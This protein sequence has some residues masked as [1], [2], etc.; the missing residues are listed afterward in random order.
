M[1]RREGDFYP[2]P[3]VAVI[4]LL[5]ELDPLLPQT[6]GPFPILVVD[7]A[8]G[9]GGLLD[10]VDIVLPRCSTLGVENN[11]STVEYIRKA[12]NCIEADFLS[13]GSL[14]S[15]T[16]LY[17]SNPPYSLAQEFVSK[18]LRERSSGTIVACLLRLGFFASARRADWW[19]EN[20]VAAI[21]ILS[22]RPSFT[23]DG[24][25]DNSDYAWFIWNP[26]SRDLGLRPIWWYGKGK[27]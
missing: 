11:A 12:H 8:A 17:L 1:T 16:A 26:P 4:D 7:P 27:K 5:N 21:R 23:G 20:P 25:T 19:R 18:M 24:K 13:L 6:N 9:R 2:T 22:N 3:Q 14:A 10:A 15:Q